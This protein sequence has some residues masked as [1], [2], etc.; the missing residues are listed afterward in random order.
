MVQPELRAKQLT[1]IACGFFARKN[2]S[3]PRPSFLHNEDSVEQI[4]SEE[5]TV[6]DE[7]TCQIQPVATQSV[8]TQSDSMSRIDSDVAEYLLF[9]SREKNSSDDGYVEHFEIWEKKNS[10]ARVFT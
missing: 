10:E 1:E 3:A 4:N 5:E 7:A 9:L 8:L 6:I 2:Y